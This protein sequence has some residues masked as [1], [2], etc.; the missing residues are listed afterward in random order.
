[1]VHRLRSIVKRAMKTLRSIVT[2]SM[3][4]RERFYHLGTRRY[5]FLKKSSEKMDDPSMRLSDRDIRTMVICMV[6]RTE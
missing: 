2:S 1:M 6:T 5:K 3:R 4:A